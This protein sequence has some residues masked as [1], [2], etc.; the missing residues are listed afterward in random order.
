MCFPWL[1][2]YTYIKILINICIPAKIAY[3]LPKYMLDIE[4]LIYPISITNQRGRWM[5]CYETLRIIIELDNLCAY[6]S[7]D[8]E[9]QT[10]NYMNVY[11]FLP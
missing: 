3:L 1:G 5:I 2:V 6:T 9:N 11:S 7:D 4:Y 8:P 10:H